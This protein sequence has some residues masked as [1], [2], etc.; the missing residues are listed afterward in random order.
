[1]MRKRLAI[2]IGATLIVIV[3][4][5]AALAQVP[6]IVS[7]VPGQNELSVSA[8]TSISIVF[9]EEMQVGTINGT[10]IVVRSK[11]GSKWPGVVGYNAPSRT[12]IFT[13]D[14]AFHTGDV[15]TV[16]LTTGIKSFTGLPLNDSYSW[17]FTVEAVGGFD[18]V[19]QR[20]TTYAFGGAPYCI[21]AID[22]DGDR[23]VDLAGGDW[24]PAA[25][26]LLRNNGAGKFG[27]GTAYD[28]ARHPEDICTGDFD[29]D[30]DQDLAGLS[31]SDSL[32]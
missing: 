29:D 16:T 8:S 11:F 6:H 4:A 2:T 23:D 7:V 32:L 19:F 24:S 17:S 3:L 9:S 21:G 5:A 27:G 18:G 15:I 1:M 10:T 26:Y 22:L 12:A 30:G 25:I 31:S 20:D 13:P 14:Y 28:F